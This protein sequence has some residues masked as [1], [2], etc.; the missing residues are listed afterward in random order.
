MTS[1]EQLAKNLV[2]HAHLNAA[3]G[4]MVWDQEVMMPHGSAQLRAQHLAALQGMGHEKFLKESGPLIE[5]ISAAGEDKLTE[6]ERLNFRRTNYDYQ[7]QRKLPTEFVMAVSQA[8]SEA[9]HRWV[10]ARSKEDFSLFAPSME[11]IVELRLQECDYLGYEENPYD[12]LLDQYE[13]G[14]K[15]S[16]LEKVFTPFKVELRALLA[17]IMDRPQ[18]ADAFLNQHIA[19]DTQMTWSETVLAAMGF[20]L[21]RG[22]QDVS[23]H[24]FSLAVD[25]NDV[26]ITTRLSDTDIREMLYSTIHEGGH[27]IYEQGLNPAHFG[28]PAAEACSLGIHE[29]QSRL[30]ENN[31]ARSLPFWEHFFPKLA[32]LYPDQL[33]GKTAE[34][35]FRAVNVVAPGFI[36]ISCDELTYHFHI[37]LRT[38]LEIELINRRLAVKDLPEAWNA[39]VKSYLG[40]DVP[41]HSLGVLQDIHWSHGSIGYFPTYSLGSFYAAQF[42][43]KAEQDLGGLSGDFSQGNFG[44]LK[45]WLNENIHSHGR[46]YSAEELC[47][48]V[49]GTGLDVKHFIAYAKEKFGK[50]YGIKI[51]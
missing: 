6:F 4:L 47:T 44:K 5:A 10:E 39:K 11:R 34:D 36:R 24:P 8:T 35:M 33:K 32:A 51:N 31:V 46:L 9:Y 42:M 49:T 41:N 23:V 21:N 40:L 37:L 29:S 2:Q 26:R 20:D 13:P 3:I 1:Y 16:T 38:E 30:W 15:A 17:Q 27:G 45:T 50:V 7:R 19:Q 25:P 43:A 28:L 48:R 18:V 14:M 12:A 22:R